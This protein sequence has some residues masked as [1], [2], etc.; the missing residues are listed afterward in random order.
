MVPCHRYDVPLTQTA[1]C[2][3]RSVIVPCLRIHGMDDTA[4]VAWKEC[5]VS[6]YRWHLRRRPGLRERHSIIIE[7]LRA[8]QPHIS[9]KSHSRPCQVPLL[10]CLGDFHTEKCGGHTTYLSIYVL[11][12]PILRRGG[13]HATRQM[14]SPSYHFLH[15][16]ALAPSLVSSALWSLILISV[17]DPRRLNC[18]SPGG[19]KDADRSITSVGRDESEDHQVDRCE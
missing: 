16:P 12:P 17:V 9:D 1:V 6:V 5:R 11:G 14:G 4:K 18:P 7:C 19:L 2:R 3:R 8:Q 13:R 15:V 10:V